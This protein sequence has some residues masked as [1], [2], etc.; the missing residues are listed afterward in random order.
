MSIEKEEQEQEQEQ[1]QEKEVVPR[2]EILYQDEYLVAV[3]KPAGLLVHRTAIAAGQTELFALQLL[4]DQ[5]GRYVYPLHRLDR[6]TSGVLLF[7]LDEETTRLVKEAFATRQV[8]KRYLALVRGYTTES[9]TID[10]PLEKWVDRKVKKKKMAK[11][12]EGKTLERQEAVTHYTRLGTAELPIP[13]GRYDTSRYSLVDITI[14]TGRTHQ[15]RRHFNHIAHPLVGDH[16][17]GDNQHNRMFRERLGLPPLFLLAYHLGLSHPYTKRPLAIEA[18]P[19]RNESW[20]QACHSLG[21]EG[22]LQSL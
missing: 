21:I 9:G 7:A 6:P 16:R 8:H 4:R 10:Y 11:L 22:Q 1:E 17:Y 12:G 5:I 18:P 3:N 2:L 13:V 19:S 20:V 15:I 14:E